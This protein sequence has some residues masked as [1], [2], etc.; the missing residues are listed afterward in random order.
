MNL[1]RVGFERPLQTDSHI[2]DPICAQKVVL[3]LEWVIDEWG[4]GLTLERQEILKV[5]HSHDNTQGSGIW[6]RENWSWWQRWA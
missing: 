6:A 2:C 5:T 1:I 3:P 4:A